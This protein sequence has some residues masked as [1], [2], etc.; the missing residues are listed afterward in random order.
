MMGRVV[1]VLLVV[2]LVGFVGVK[3]LPLGV[4]EFTSTTT[5]KKFPVPSF[6]MPKDECCMY[7]VTFKTVRGVWALEQ[8]VARI[9]ESDF[10]E[11]KC[12][13]S[14]EKKVYYNAA[15]DITVRA[16]TVNLGFPL[17]ELV[18]SYDLGKSC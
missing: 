1:R 15:E 13:T 4:S 8:E 12:A 3:F 2:A 18:V 5:G 9:L 14:N 10:E 6:M 16:Y 11:I 17:N 7:A